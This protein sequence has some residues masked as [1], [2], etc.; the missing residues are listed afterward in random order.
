MKYRKIGSY[1]SSIEALTSI[2]K[3]EH[4]LRHLITPFST[5][6]LSIILSPQATLV[7]D[8]P[9]VNRGGDKKRSVDGSCFA[10]NKFAPSQ[11][12]SMAIAACNI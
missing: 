2:F 7:R 5:S 11:E 9:K 12:S 4:D 3:V 6:S 10:C 1:L 8:A